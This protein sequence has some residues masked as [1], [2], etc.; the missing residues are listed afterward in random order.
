MTYT[1]LQILPFR[2]CQSDG[3]GD[4][5]VAIAKA[6]S[7]GHGIN[8]HF[9]VARPDDTTAAVD[10]GFQST[11]LPMCNAASLHDALVGAPEP[12]ALLIHVSGYGYSRYGAP[13]WLSK[14]IAKW[15]RQQTKPVPIIGIF[16]ELFTDAPIWNRRYWYGLRQKAFIR[17]MAQFCDHIITPTGDYCRWL[18]QHCVLRTPPMVMPVVSTVGELRADTAN[19]TRA[20]RLVIFARGGGADLVYSQWLP[21]VEQAV[22]AYAI[23]EIIDIGARSTTPPSAVGG[24]NL[25]AYGRVA[26]EEV[27]ELLRTCRFGFLAY[28]HMPLAK[29]TILAA[30]SAHGVIPLCAIDDAKQQDGLVAGRNFVHVSPMSDAV[31]ISQDQEST[32]RYSIV[33]WYAVHNSAAQARLLSGMMNGG[34]T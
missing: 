9:I 6:L 11:T 12:V 32:L 17:K 23:D 8:S 30:Y 29:S 4:Y 26:A 19:A 2:S 24:A 3:V 7:I 33:D 20:N 13:F 25:T 18:E 31:S 14:A 21:Q 28:Q 22:C 34:L 15:A 5:A 10:D 16:H 27:S 1:L